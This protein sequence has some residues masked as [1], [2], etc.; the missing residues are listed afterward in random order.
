MKSLKQLRTDSTKITHNKLD[1]LVGTGLL[2]ET[3]MT[4]IR[5]A[6]DRNNLKQTPAEHNALVDLVERMIP[7][8]EAVILG[9]NSP[10]ISSNLD[11]TQIPPLLIL[12]R[13]AIRVFPGGEKVALYW[14]DRINKY[15]SVPF[16]SI[17]IQESTDKKNFT[18]ADWDKLT[19]AGKA[20]L[21]PALTDDEL[22]SFEPGGPPK[23]DREDDERK[24][25][26]PD[27]K[28][29][30][31]TPI[32]ARALPTWSVAA[33]PASAAPAK[34]TKPVVPPVKPPSAPTEK[35]T[36]HDDLK[37][38][39]ARARALDK[40]RKESEDEEDRQ[41]HLKRNPAQDFAHFHKALSSSTRGPISHLAAT[42]AA[43]IGSTI[44]KSIY[45]ART[46]R[47]YEGK[48]IQVY[49]KKLQEEP[50]VLPPPVKVPSPK[51]P[52]AGEGDPTTNIHR[53]S[54][55]NNYASP[56]GPGPVDTSGEYLPHSHARTAFNGTYVQG[57]K[58]V[59]EPVE[60]GPYDRG[61]LAVQNVVLSRRANRT[62]ADQPDQDRTPARKMDEGVYTILK[63]M[64]KKNIET[65][66]VQ[67]GE[68]FVPVTLG[69]AK[70][71]LSLYEGINK[72]NQSVMKK[73]LNENSNSFYK[74][75]E[76]AVRKL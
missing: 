49:R 21:R 6:L 55:V 52:A 45:K 24:D 74:I 34:P 41:A 30:S 70:R 48:K 3:N 71:I 57:N 17:G 36:L 46:G 44:G 69:Q 59:A 26:R 76:F 13:R 23:E 18:K 12:H 60:P 65:Q 42:A 56:N 66:D 53:T 54:I 47:L 51:T 10:P 1:T 72:A 43:T 33:S 37:N 38:K 11:I 25:M 8:Q 20:R 63:E 27:I 4:L 14:A 64:V 58:P 61:A 40:A 22:K 39:V 7:T 35:P 2:E 75:L 5:R 28:A 68:E 31:G 73:M 19:P 16:Q 9:E 32:T 29:P 67:I 62:I 15:I 50:E